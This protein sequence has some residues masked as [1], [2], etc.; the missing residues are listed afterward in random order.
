MR[1]IRSKSSKRKRK[2]RDVRGTQDFGTLSERQ[3]RKRSNAVRGTVLVL[4]MFAINEGDAGVGAA[5]GRERKQRLG[6]AN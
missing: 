1:E 5:V 3:N 6:H 4:C 2:E